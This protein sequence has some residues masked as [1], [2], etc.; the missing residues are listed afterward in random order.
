MKNWKKL[1][2]LGII[3]V[4]AF[5]F[6]G[7]DNDKNNSENKDD[8]KNQADL[9]IFGDGLTAKVTGK[10]TDSQW[11]I[12]VPK[13]KTALNTASTGGG[14]LEADCKALF[15]GWT[16]NIVLEFTKAYDHY[17]IDL[18][19]VN[20]KLNADFVINASAGDL[21]TWVETMVN[22]TFGREPEQAKAVPVRD[23]FQK[24]YRQQIVFYVYGKNRFII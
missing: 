12:A 21:F 7:C 24:M 23:G 15:G 18:V 1:N 4:F 11:A 17:K 8:R 22:A 2:V 14:Q 10:M 9:I 13:L 16:M 3:L 20:M 6:I 5:G 19:E